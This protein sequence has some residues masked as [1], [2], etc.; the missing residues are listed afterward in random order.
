MTD[1]VPNKYTVGPAILWTPF[2]IT[3]HLLTMLGEYF[4]LP[5]KSD[6]YTVLYQWFIGL[7]SIIYGL[8]G[9]ILI[10]RICTFFFQKH[11]A[12]ISTSFVAL[13]TNVFYYLTNE[14]T[15]SHAMS[16]FAVSLF[17]FISIQDTEDYDLKQMFLLGLSGGLMI[18]IRPQNALFFVLMVPKLSWILNIGSS[19]IEKFRQRMEG[20]GVLL[21]T[22]TMVLL[23]QFIV[24]KILYGHYLFYSYE[25]EGFNF[26]NPHLLDTLFSARHGLISWTPGILLSLAGLISF[27]KIE[28]R[29][30]LIFSIAFI[31]QWYINA[32]WHCWW[33][34]HSFGGRA[35]INCS[36]IFAVGIAMFLTKIDQQPIKHIMQLFFALLILWNIQFA[37]QLTIGM[38]PGEEAVDFKQVF[39]NQLKLPDAIMEKFLEFKK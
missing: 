5:L 15:M 8:L 6:G 2:F 9:L 35:Y 13:G 7:G 3:A 17:A 30:A 28:R 33:F 10:Y 19:S 38:V 4:G 1:H 20:W 27:Y 12:L 37:A 23:P 22:F 29:F 11:V 31:L 36:F 18:L 32:S 39:L 34:G 26:M 24:W 25:G 14:P 16:L 21:F